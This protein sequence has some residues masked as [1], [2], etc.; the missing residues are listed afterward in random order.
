[1]TVEY[2]ELPEDFTIAGWADLADDLLCAGQTASDIMNALIDVY[3]NYSWFVLVQDNTQGY[4]GSY[5]GNSEIHNADNL[6]G[7]NMVVWMN[8][9]ST[10]DCNTNTAGASAQRLIDNASSSGSTPSTIMNYITSSKDIIQ[11]K[12]L[13]SYVFR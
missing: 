1:M 12:K 3:P 4:S 11:V 10:Q 7:K 5:G 8:S 9:G 6:C 13:Y 2:H